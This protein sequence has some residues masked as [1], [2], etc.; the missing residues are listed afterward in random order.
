[1]PAII[2]HDTFGRETYDDLFSLIGGSK[3][4]VD[5]FLLGNQGPDP[6][7][8]SVVNLRLKSV[9]HLGGRMHHEHTNE[10]LVAL[11]RSV[12]L[13]DACDQ[14]VARAYALGFLCHYLLDSTMH[15]FVYW[16]EYEACDAGEPGL[17]RDDG[18]E[19]HAVIESELDELVLF[20]KRGQTVATFDPS[21]EILRASNRVLSVVSRMY[22]YVAMTTYGLFIPQNAF[23]SSVKCFRGVQ[24]LFHSRDG[25][26]RDMLAR[27][28]TMF[29]RYSF[30]AAMSH[31]PIEL[32]ESAFD[33]RDHRVWA[34][35]FTHEESSD[36]FWDRYAMARSRTEDAL[37]AFARDDFD[38][39]AVR[40]LTKD[41]DFS[42]EP[43]Y[44]R[45][46]SVE[47][48][49]Q[50]GVASR[51]EGD[52]Q[53]GVESSQVEGASQ[54]GGSCRTDCADSR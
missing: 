25:V 4:E 49:S 52:V 46:V 38:E 5:A 23:G 8:Y 43:T 32:T 13:Q 48:A 11:R 1:M 24:A 47:G 18:S 34:N 2:T 50:G 41:L 37:R 36:S 6:L 44:A 33:N 26:K 12:E 17:C 21:S 15:P 39:A 16:Q 14:R 20:S 19:V 42:G 22:A 29:R 30:Y 51:G 9:H 53:D 10:L 54:V 31:R 28:E 7:F 35:P 3:D 40:A 45:I 27:F